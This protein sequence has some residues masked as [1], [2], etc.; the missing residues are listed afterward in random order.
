MIL[1]WLAGLA[2]TRSGTFS[3][4]VAGIAVTVGFL[5]SIGIFMRSSAA[6]MTRRA[7]EDVPIDWQVEVAPGR[8]DRRHRRG[9]A[10]RLAYRPHRGGGLCC[11]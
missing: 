9:D 10:E 8:L 4:I 1:A 3:G 11:Q 5:A 6:E 7:T 2:R